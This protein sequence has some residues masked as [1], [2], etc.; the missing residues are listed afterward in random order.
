MKQESTNSSEKDKPTQLLEA[1]VGWWDEWVSADNPAE[2]SDPPIAEI[3][4]FLLQKKA[5]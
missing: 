4:A 3:K 1:V 5:L 2:I